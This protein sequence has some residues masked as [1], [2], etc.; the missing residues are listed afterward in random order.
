M[1]PHGPKT[2]M[3]TYGGSYPGPT[4]VRPAGQ[5][6]KVTFINRL[7][8]VGRRDHGPSARRPP[9]WQDDG[10]P[11]RFLIHHGGRRTYNY[12]LTDDGRPETEA[13]D[14]YH[15]HRMN[16]TGRNNWYGLQG[17]FIINDKRERVRFPRGRYDLPLMVSDRS[18]TGQ[19]PADRPVPRP[20][21]IDVRQEGAAGASRRRRRSATRSWSTAGSRRTC[22]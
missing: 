1:L 17:M 7:P 22:T 2:W 16:E 12:P 3:W 14:W 15:D 9:R 10:Q 20:H 11:N 8:Q 4:I 18:F 5:D 21:A 13:F 6:T 19:E